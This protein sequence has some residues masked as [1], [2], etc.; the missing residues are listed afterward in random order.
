[1]YPFKLL[2]SE[3]VLKNKFSSENE[4]IFGNKRSIG[5]RTLNTTC[6]SCSVQQKW[7]SL[8]FLQHGSNKTLRL[9]EVPKLHDNILHWSFA[10]VWCK[11]WC[12]KCRHIAGNST[13]DQLMTI[14]VASYLKP[15][16][17]WKKITHIHGLHWEK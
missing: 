10:V 16:Y 1:M 15:C 14:N 13:A 17:A 11:T 4:A 12:Y 8:S 3:M 9:F 2:W 6:S 5:N 7:L